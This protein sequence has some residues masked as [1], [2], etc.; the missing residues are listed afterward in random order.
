MRLMWS[1]T[2]LIWGTI[3]LSSISAFGQGGPSPAGMGWTES[4]D[5]D[6]LEASGGTLLMSTPTTDSLAEVTI[7]FTFNF[8]GNDFTSIFVADNGYMTFNDYGV[9][10]FVGGV[11]DD[12]DLDTTPD[13]ILAVFWDDQIRLFPNGNIYTETFGLAPYRQFVIQYDQVQQSSGGAFMDF[14]VILY[15][16]LNL[17]KFQYLTVGALPPD[18]GSEATIGVKFT[19]DDLLPTQDSLAYSLS[20]PS[21][22]DNLPVIFHPLDIL[23]A[24]T[25][26][27]SPSQVDIGTVFQFFDLDIT[28]VQLSSAT[29]LQN[30]GKADVLAIGNPFDNTVDTMYVF[31]VT[32][33]GES[34]ALQHRQTPPTPDEYSADMK[35]VTWYYDATVDSLYLQVPPLGIT[36]T[37]SVNFLVEIPD[38][39]SLGAYNFGTEVY[40]RFDRSNAATGTA[41]FTLGSDV[42]DHFV[43]NP[44]SD[45]SIVAGTNPLG[46]LQF[47]ITAE[48]EFGNKVINGDTLDY[49]ALGSTTADFDPDFSTFRNL[50]DSVT[51]RVADTVAGSFVLRATSRLDN[52]TTVSSGVITILPADPAQ[53]TILNSLDPLEV[54]AT[55]RLSVR[56]EDQFGNVHTDSTVS[57]DIISGDAV[58][59]NSQTTSSTDVTDALGIAELD[60]RASTLTSFTSDS[61]EVSFGSITD[62]IVIPLQA[63]AISRF[64]LTIT[65][66]SSITAG[67]TTTIQVEALDAFD[68]PVISTEQIQAT[69]L[70]TATA[71]FTPVS[72]L[73][74]FANSSTLTITVSDNTVGDFTVQA[75]LVSDAS[76]LGV[77]PEITVTAGTLT[78][79]LI[80][81]AASNGG[82]ALSNVDTT[83]LSTQTLTMYAAGY[84]AFGNYIGDIAAATWDSTNTNGNLTPSPPFVFPFTDSRFV[85]NASNSGNGSVF[86][87]ATGATPDTTGIITITPGTLSFIRIQ[88]DSTDVN[89]EL[90]SLAL[91]AGATQQMFAVGY[92]NDNNRI[93]TVNADWSVNN[94][95]LGT[96]T[97]SGAATQTNTNEVTFSAAGIGNGIV[98]AVAV[99]DNTVTDDTGLITVTA[100][101]VAS[102]V[103]RN[104]ANNGGSAY[105]SPL[106]VSTD[107]SIVLY[108]AAYDAFGNYVEDRSTTWA[109]DEFTLDNT[110]PASSITFNPTT[111]GSGTIY[112]TDGTATNDTTATLTIT[113][114]NITS[115]V[116]QSDATAGGTEV[117]SVTL[118][119]GQDT[120][121]FA[122]GYDSDGNF[123][124]S[125]SSDWTLEGDAIGDFSAANPA[126]SNT[127]QSDSI[128]S[129]TVRATENGGSLTDITS[130]I[131]VVAGV[132]DSIAKE[133]G[134][135]QTAPVS[136]QL[137]QDIEVAVFDVFGNPVEGQT[138][139]FIP[140]GGG[141]AS[142]TSAVTDAL[143]IASTSW[144]VHSTTEDDSLAAT[145]TGITTTPD[146]LVF[147]AT[148]TGGAADTLFASSALTATG[149]VDTDLATAFT[150]TVQD[151]G[152]NPIANAIVNFNIVSSPIGAI[153]DSLLTD[154][155]VLTDASGQASTTLHLGS[156]IG[157]YVVRASTGITTPNFIDFTGTADI[158]NPADTILIVSGNGQTGAVNTALTDSI[159]FQVVDDFDNVLSGEVV[160]FTAIDG[161]VAPASA[162]SDANG[163]VATEWTLG[164]TAGT[165]ELVASLQSNG[166]ITSDTVT[167]TGEASG[168]AAVE[169][170]SMRGIASDSIAALRGEEVAFQVRAVDG[171][172]NPVANEI[173]TFEAVPGYSPTFLLGQ[174]TTDA[175]GNGLGLVTTD[176]NQ[177]STYF[178]ALISGVDT[179]ELHLYSLDYFANTLSP[180]SS[181]P[182][183]TEAFELTLQ[184]NAYS[185]VTVSTGSAFEFD[186][187]ANFYSAGLASQTTIPAR[188]SI[189]VV[190]NSVQIPAGFA[191]TTYTPTIAVTG[192]DSDSLLLGN[193]TLPFAAL[194]LSTVEI[195]TI[196]ADQS[197]VARGESFTATMTVSN[198]SADTVAVDSV[199][200]NITGGSPIT[201]TPLVTPVELLP[202]TPT[203]LFTFTV[204][205]PLTADGGDRTIDG[206]FEGTTD[207]GSQIVDGDANSTFLFSII[208]NTEVAIVDESLT[209]TTLTN[210]ESFDFFVDLLT[211]GGFDV[212]LNSDSTYLTFGTDSSFLKQSYAAPSG[213]A[214]TVEFESIPITSAASL[215][216]YDATVRLYGT[217]NSLVYDSTFVI[218]D[219]I[220]VQNQPN[221]TVA[222]T[223][224]PPDT[225]SQGQQNI[226]VTATLTNNGP[227]AADAIIS[228]PD[229]ISLFTGGG[230]SNIIPST[231]AITLASGE[232]SAPLDFTFSLDESY[233]TGLDSVR[234]RYAYTDGNSSRSRADTSQ[235]QTFE[236]LSRSII[237]LVS[238]T[239]AIAPDTATA[240]E[241][242]LIINFVLQNVG[243]SPA[244]IDNVSDVQLTFN[245]NHTT[246]ITIPT[247]F[248]A[249]IPAGQIRSFT[250][251]L[252]IAADA[253]TGVDPVDLTATYVDTFS[254][255]SYSDLVENNVDTLVI[256]SGAAMNILSVLAEN[257]TES[258]DSVSIGAQNVPVAIR[259]ENTGAGDLQLDSLSIDFVPAGTYTGA[260]TI[261]AT[262]PVLTPGSS[263]LFNFLVDV[264]GA[265]TSGLVTLGATAYGQDVTSGATI[266]ESGADTTDSWRLV[267]AASL[268]FVSISPSQV[269]VGQDVQFTI[270]LQNSGEANVLLDST[271]TFLVF[272]TDT[273]FLDQNTVVEGNSTT[274]ITLDSRII[275]FA[276]T[277]PLTGTLFINN[278]QENGFTNS[279]A[280]TPVDIGV[281]DGADLVFQT[282]DAP[283]SV[284]QDQ[285]F[286]INLTVQNANA[287]GSDAVVDSVIVEGLDIARSE[288][289]TVVGGASL[290]L[291]PISGTFDTSVSG[292]TTVLVEVVWTDNLTGAVTTIDTSLTITVLGKA[293]LLVTDVV[294]PAIV[295]PGETIDSVLVQVTNTGSVTADLLSVSF[296]PQIGVYSQIIAD[297]G[298]AASIPGGA[299]VDLYYDFVVASN[300]GTGTDSVG[301]NVTA[302]DSLSLET[303]TADS[304]FSWA[305]QTSGN[306][307]ITAIVPGQT[308]VSQGQ[309]DALVSVIVSNLGALDLTVDTLNLAFTN[310]NGNYGGELTRSFVAGTEVLEA[311]STRQYDFL[312]DVGAAATLGVDVIDAS[313]SAT[314]TGTSLELNA[315]SS[316][317]TGS[318]TVQ[319]APALGLTTT[320]DTDTASTG[321]SD[322]VYTYT[323]TNTGTATQTAGVNIDSV[324]L[325][326]DGIE[327]DFTNLSFTALST[328]P[329]TLAGGDSFTV[330]YDVS[331]LA[332]ALPA[333]YVATLEVYYEDSNDA[334]LVQTNLSSSQTLTVVSGVN[335]ELAAMLLPGDTVSVGQTGVRDTVRIRNNSGADA[336]VISS[337][338]TFSPAL[339]FTQTL[340]EPL[341]LP[342]TVVAGDSL[343][344]IYEVDVPASAAP[345]TFVEIGAE[346]SAL[347][348][349]SNQTVTLD[350]D[351]AASFTIVDGPF[352]SFDS[353]GPLAFNASDA[354]VFELVITNSGDAA[355]TLDGN[356][357]FLVV[358]AAPGDTA[359]LDIAQSN[360]VFGPGVQDTL[361][362]QTITLTE[363]GTFLPVATLNGSSDGSPFS[364]ELETSNI[365]VGGDF[366][367]S[368]FDI[369]PNGVV[370]GE[371]GVQAIV[372]ITSQNELVVDPTVTVSF[373]YTSGGIFVPDNFTRIDAIDTIRVGIP[374]DLTWQFDIPAA[375]DSGDV[376]ATAILNFNSG[377][378]DTTAVTTFVIQSGVE[379][380]FGGNLSPAQ[381][382]PEEGVVFSAEVTNS[383]NTDLL[384]NPDLSFLTFTDGATTFQAEVNGAIT[385]RGAD[386]TETRTTVVPFVLDTIPAAMLAGAYSFDVVLDG[387]MPNGQDFDV[388]TL[389]SGT[390]VVTVLTGA[391][392]TVDAIDVVPDTVTLGQSFVE[393]QYTLTNNGQSD[394]RINNLNSV[395]LD[396]L[397]QDISADWLTVFN[398]DNFPFVLDSAATDTFIRR[399]NVLNSGPTG[400]VSAS[401]NGNYNDV[402]RTDP[403]DT[404]SLNSGAITDVVQ[405]IG[406]SGVFVDSLNIDPLTVINPP[407]V[408]YGQTFNL[409][410]SINN[411]GDDQLLVYV[412]ILKNGQPFVTDTLQA[413][414][415]LP[416]QSTVFTYPDTADS[417]S[418]TIVYT[419]II[420]SAISQT[421]GDQINPGQAVDNTESVQVQEA[422]R[423]ALTASSDRSNLTIGQQFNVTFNIDEFGESS[424]DGTGQVTITLPGNY[425]LVNPTTA[426]LP[427]DENLLTGTWTISAD[428]STQPVGSVDSIEIDMTSI[429]LDLNVNQPVEINPG[430]DNAVVTVATGGEVNI[431]SNISIIE[432]AGAIDRI[433]STSQQFT[434]QNSF[435]FTGEI[436]G[437][438]R[439]TRLQFPS[440]RDYSSNGSL[441]LALDSLGS[442]TTWTLF[443][444]STATA[445][446]PDEII[447]ET[448]GRDR[449]TGLIVT[450]VDTLFLTV[451]ERATL[452]L[453]AEVTEPSGAQDD[454]VSTFQRFVWK[455][456]VDNLGTAAMTDS[457][458]VQLT[459]PAGGFFFDSLQTETTL[460]T[461]FLPQDSVFVNV[462]TDSVANGLKTV[463]ALVNRFPLDANSGAE[464]IVQNNPQ[465]VSK[466][467]IERADLEIRLIGPSIVDVAD[468]FAVVAE[469]RNIG[470]ALVDPDSVE[471][472]ISSESYNG[473]DL[474]ASDTTHKF[475]QLNGGLSGQV[476][477]QFV[478]GPTPGPQD[479]LIVDII[480]VAASDTNNFGDI[481]VF[482]SQPNFR[483]PIEVQEGAVLVSITEPAD[484]AIVSTGEPF[485]VT[486]QLTYSDNVTEANRFATIDPPDDFQL[487]GATPQ[488]VEVSVTN[489]TVSWTLIAP[490]N[491]I[492]GDQVITV[493]GTGVE[494]FTGV[495]LSGSD[496][497]TVQL[498]QRAELTP[499]IAIVAPDSAAIN[500]RV[501]TGQAFDVDVWVENIDD[502]AVTTGVDSVRL[503]LPVDF[504]FGDV[505]ASDSLIGINVGDTTTVR[506][507]AAGTLRG[508]LLAIDARLEAASIDENTGEPAFISGDSTT[509]VTFNVQRAA[510]LRITAADR[511]FARNQTS[512]IAV[513]IQNVGEAGILPGTI[514]VA[515]VSRNT[516]SLTINDPDTVTVEL[517]NGVATA[518][519]S[520]TAG[521]DSTIIADSVDVRIVE[522]FARDDN[523]DESVEA[524]FLSDSTAFGYL[525]NTGGVSIAQANF[526]NDDDSLTV[527]TGQ[528]GITIVLKSVISPLYDENRRATIIMPSD[529][530]SPDTLTRE[531]DSDSLA[532][533]IPTPASDTTDGWRDIEVKIEATA[534]GDGFTLS[535]SRIL[536]VFVQ[537]AANLVLTSGLAD[538]QGTTISFGQTFDYEAIVRN[539]G[540]A[541][542]DAPGELTLTFDPENLVLVEGDAAQSFEIDSTVSWTL[543]ANDNSEAKALSKRINDLELKKV[544][545]V[546][547]SQTMADED[548]GAVTSAEAINAEINTLRN[549]LNG[550][551]EVAVVKA[552]VSEIPLDA[553]SLQPAVVSIQADSVTLLI[554]EEPTIS[555]I[556]FQVP[557][558][559]S[560]G[561]TLTIIA[562][563]D[564]PVNVIDREATLTLPEGLEFVASPPDATKPISGS[565]VSWAVQAAD[566]VEGGTLTADV[567][568]D[569]TGRDAND[570]TRVVN[571][572]SLASI[573]IENAATI[574]LQVSDFV[575]LQRNQ[576]FPVRATLIRGG[577]AGITGMV[578]VEAFNPGPGFSFVSDSVREVSFGTE[579]SIA[580]DWT[581]L[582][583]DTASLNVLMTLRITE[584]PTDDNTGE[585][586]A[587]IN[588]EQRVPLTL[589]ARQLL[590]ERL[591]E[592]EPATTYLQ[593]DT[594]VPVIGLAFTNNN[595]ADSIMIRSFTVSVSGGVGDT[596]ELFEDPEALISA[597]R[598]VR[599]TPGVTPFE[600][601]EELASVNLVSDNDNPFALTF[602]PETPVLAR[603]TETMAILVD[604]ADDAPNTTFSLRLNSVAAVQGS[605]G[606]NVD[607]IDT[608]GVAVENQVFAFNS[609]SITIFDKDPANNFGNYPN[610]FGFHTAPEGGET[611]TTWYTFTLERDARVEL[612]IYT[613]L[614]KLVRTITPEVEVQRAGPHSGRELIWDGLNGEGRRV[615]NG[616][617]VAILKVDFVDGGSAEYRTK[618]VYI[619]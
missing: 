571:D 116:I 95:S 606:G 402:R 188:D 403:A 478:S 497:V 174:A 245:N 140:L 464:V 480:D 182:G 23:T 273:L 118:T 204:T 349:N 22:S 422:R 283:D 291:N 597:M 551:M 45:T 14:Q 493:T 152:D 275:D 541:D 30:M 588:R 352:F 347:D 522:P 401:L 519:F 303:L 360:L 132:A 253:G 101:T 168:V 370:P 589:V 475:V 296:D 18:R 520:V 151:A 618:T 52:N 10:N 442:D 68:N 35:R 80:R 396:S 218:S 416:N 277:D 235:A 154:N 552:E 229:S 434:V 161:S 578:K 351:S 72:G 86:I 533:I 128:G 244:R 498:Q 17:V 542:I 558:T 466:V 54:S 344:L 398:S 228:R 139:D 209:P 256:V 286:N 477:Y 450:R 147:R 268:S 599:F 514:S 516:D 97:G 126:T 388:V 227:N 345:G 367:I 230:L 240:G 414:E 205:V 505:V 337:T 563:V 26:A 441:T 448:S 609:G 444:P 484:A 21:L 292:D 443:G 249:I 148:V 117:E 16:T 614:G 6:W 566:S 93:G 368:L 193:I 99:S 406:A 548:G 111:A 340:V 432:P 363:T 64:S 133:G 4:V 506:V 476:E 595:A 468:T 109:S 483:Q 390:D 317:V 395:F 532:I 5:F 87:S 617:Y 574:D 313:G 63:A 495:V 600:A 421:S 83:I 49:T 48:D 102:I 269:T 503:L 82:R 213:I 389:S 34:F 50:L 58:F 231:T 348:Q 74:T 233:T 33:D 445:G 535:D 179:L 539:N 181:S 524:L 603:E 160:N 263:Q 114:G 590:I 452:S 502:A 138:V 13:S 206:Y 615:V 27:A 545:L 567:T 550:M 9:G 525:I 319:T 553:N 119:A 121:L 207:A 383:G 259:L 44:S 243:G 294:A 458:G 309:Q 331:V 60:Y 437:E 560:S 562:N 610:P 122:V 157:D 473:F 61:I 605:D 29:D 523:T 123:V 346:I 425:S 12:L 238:N 56:L 3:L 554:Q 53:F 488:T 512:N 543:Q 474:L 197:I 591:Q 267:T 364:Q 612:R 40:T 169:L 145:I 530:F 210:G 326:I 212:V 353:L 28:N 322:I 361:V 222:F 329:T 142:P 216:Q 62:T 260:D 577:T 580:L 459:T 262:P 517:V 299:T 89:S 185:D 501:S 96:F 510:E 447:V 412:S 274:T 564:A 220:L 369:V 84:D 234:I 411:S 66:S 582:A 407:F 602:T 297:A 435:V 375:A 171:S 384:V 549:K 306:F 183:N 224:L 25:A 357:T 67:N 538:G 7:P 513:Q 271:Q 178:R 373:Q 534:S 470:T 507:R 491:L 557:E 333:D 486:A 608:L 270:D 527:S 76:K 190:F 314:E 41:A 38:G 165:Q 258:F 127:L 438:G 469:V 272:G 366:A 120:A 247:T 405:V 529:V 385:V 607:V 282:V 71:S 544:A 42:V 431:I 289:T 594:D 278:Y 284:S 338:L 180:A 79:L 504:R 250:A 104:G 433:I 110:G 457:V 465:S 376:E 36:A 573:T 257:A 324:R 426:T 208:N 449:N 462:F 295:N 305:I 246:T 43:I 463:Q 586:V 131:T 354:A 8:Y 372:R 167:A 350:V 285:T 428:D 241:E 287:T 158:A 471:I 508:T 332:T 496:N 528:E 1:K 446:T 85:L 146:T 382:V 409:D 500:Q 334:S 255:V 264:D 81:D 547:G 408:N 399:F 223:Q 153:N 592:P 423:L 236:V 11:N 415:L 419:A 561:Q 177:D 454:V 77:S 537:D 199:S 143:G 194:S 339:G 569:V 94:T 587:V 288:G 248:P 75:E 439:S 593:G 487:S 598:V 387:T 455:L 341:S 92:D 196:T 37:I 65:G 15:E 39:I 159:K 356:N 378:I 2:W 46:G 371:T 203:N 164:S 536:R 494:V 509:S 69:A 430:D 327:D 300:T 261:F 559:V 526:L 518:T 596:D 162:T 323:V 392:V 374:A 312:V 386:S 156:K 320:L 195:T 265:N 163:E 202:N 575:S 417:T 98:T 252:D 20:T 112:T 215:T 225:T 410:L 343:D 601:E 217:A 200:L 328:P 461:V 280:L 355:V 302:Q 144:T 130:T 362:F 149:Q 129:A 59:V 301:V 391:D 137:P 172:G 266:V 90:G 365:L 31:G 166:A 186:D 325:L 521:P 125:V 24:S 115:L 315:T 546:T 499:Q 211:S 381:V 124:G 460:D 400:P 555:V 613:L 311:D 293:G 515:M 482:K 279:V 336:N 413:A 576:A 150:V 201:V 47:G 420:D 307:V 214:T 359:F 276:V 440:G 358:D 103:L 19:N 237:Q 198:L 611:G 485:T 436:D 424:F 57:F 55:R 187:G 184:N 453:S 579:S 189:N 88:T 556:D 531:I 170:V 136:S 540:E 304:S 310:G 251:D 583:P 155:T 221:I 581:L 616:V 604:L 134:D 456:K 141:S 308:T 192:G 427:F 78:E 32:V 219:T 73:Y 91:G 429:P 342:Q 489:P 380:A 281:F 254:L 290:V 191:N 105:D 242:N 418:E 511:N 565:S 176:E 570:T 298:N 492:A 232:T 100:G 467:T 226:T 135:N 585:E 318:W 481:P 106:T 572:N 584:V 619:K 335:L 404:L 107:S 175:N 51:V 113:A 239:F 173:I 70:G 379:L 479:T 472:A 316:L 451:E 330:I 490:Q 321:Q 397:D 108:A 394:A 377:G 568:V 393:V